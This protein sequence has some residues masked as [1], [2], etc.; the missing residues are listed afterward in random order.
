MFILSKKV[1]YIFFILKRDGRR[2]QILQH[3]LGGLTVLLLSYSLSVFQ[4]SIKLFSKGKR[5]GLN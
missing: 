5:L 4:K 1:Y 3:A 2:E